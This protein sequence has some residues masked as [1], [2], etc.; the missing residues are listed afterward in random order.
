M[1]LD[2][3]RCDEA[4]LKR[5]VTFIDYVRNREDSDVHVLV[6]TQRTGS[7]GTQYLLQFIGHGPFRGVDQSLT[8]SAPQTATADEIRGGFAQLFKL[9]LVRYA[10]E[11]P[12]ADRLGVTFNETRG[13]HAAPVRDPWNFWVF[14]IGGGGNFAGEETSSTKAI[15]GSLRASRTTEQWRSAF[16][17]NAN[18]RESRFKVDKNDDGSGTVLSV[19]R[20]NGVDG[21]VVKSVTEHWSLGL[22]ASAISSTFRNY[23]LRVRV[24]PGVE[25]NVFPYS[26]SSRRKLTVEYTVG[27]DANDY[28]EETVFGRTAERLVDHRLELGLGLRQPWGSAAA[29][30]NYSQFLSDPSKYSVGAEGNL[31]VRLFK[32]FS[33]NISGDVVRPRDQIY[34]RRGT[35]TTEEI[36]LRQRQL[37]TNYSYFL[38]FGVS[39]SFGSIF[40][41]IVN[42]RFGGAGGF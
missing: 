36:L 16:S 11:S 30:V 6:T 40:N 24:A 10:A 18:Y 25:Y 17:V 19:R 5:E 27:V 3:S 2:C 26:E 13:E 33:F 9:G 20:D 29:Q 22:S 32:G 12:L 14:R 42:P 8:Y 7:G 35:A 15:N 4:F 21:L 28:I 34:L 41:N 37:A 31:N 38:G 39:Y 23:D 1:F